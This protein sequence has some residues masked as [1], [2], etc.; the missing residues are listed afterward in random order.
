[1]PPPPYRKFLPGIIPY[2]NSSSPTLSLTEI[3]PPRHYPL[4]K[5]L[6]P[7]IIPYRNSSSR[8]YPLQKF[9]LLQIESLF[10]NSS[11]AY[12]PLQKAFLLRLLSPTESL[13]PPPLIPYRKLPPPVARQIEATIR[14]GPPMLF[15]GLSEALQTQLESVLASVLVL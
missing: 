12:Y 4:Q 14:F 9:L 7:D 8:D 6:L 11:S 2:R 10:S 3:P 15:G 1:M 5:I 13:L